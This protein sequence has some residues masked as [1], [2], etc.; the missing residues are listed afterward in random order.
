MVISTPRKTLTHSNIAR[1]VIALARAVKTMLSM[2]VFML[3]ALPMLWV[4][5]PAAAQQS[6]EQMRATDVV[7]GFIHCIET[8]NTEL[9]MNLLGTP[10]YHDSSRVITTMAEL[11]TIIEGSVSGNKRFPN[12]SYSVYDEVNRATKPFG[13]AHIDILVTAGNERILFRVRPGDVYKIVG[14]AAAN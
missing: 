4:S 5:M 13:Q 14:L 9:C 8:A 3:S 11:R 7:K 12:V 1:P 10:Y 2:P 6:S